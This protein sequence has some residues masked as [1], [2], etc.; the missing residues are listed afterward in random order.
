MK[1][2]LIAQ[3]LDSK[4]DNSRI[5]IKGW[6]RTKRD[7]KGFSFLEV[8]DGSC[9]KNIQII[10]DASNPAYEILGEVNTG[11]A[12]EVTG[13]L[14]PSPGKGQKWEVRANDIRVIGH[15]DAE[16]YPLQKKRHSDEF[17]RTIAHLR[18]RTNKYGALFRIRSESAFAVHQFFRNRG[19]YYLHTPIITGLDCE[20]AGELFRVTTLPPVSAEPE[21]ADHLFE[22]D[23]F[24]KEASL[25]VS[26]QLE[27]EMFACA[28]GNVYTFGPTFRAENSN[29]PRHS[30][31]F[32]MIEP[33]MAFA[34][35]KDN[36]DLSEELVKNLIAHVI[37][38]CGSDLELFSRFVDKNLVTQLEIIAKESYVR[39]PYGEAIE[40]LKAS[41]DIFE[42]PVDFGTDLQTE[43]ERFLCEKHFKKP[44]IVY[45]YPKQIK[46]FYMRLNDDNTTVA[47]MDLL[48]P[49]IGELIGGSQREER[50]AVLKQRI[51]ES[52]LNRD[53]YW[54]YLDIR[55]FGTAPHSGFGLGFE[56]F[57]MMV[58]GVT[59]IRDV[60]PFPRTPRHL[61]F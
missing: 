13:A 52:G 27:A 59:N 57:L 37:D 11:A 31:E 12:V 46:P 39:L 14:V 3:A 2:T 38:H 56:R 15:A 43:H 58:S 33:E 16:S 26:G 29:T 28:L 53:D 51:D 50:L 60:I 19:F 1:R 20:G 42:F 36:M 40:I 5:L 6:V 47:A 32:W 61:E 45:N 48:V 49:K 41:G 9:L 17:L 25:T 24:G 44:V 22:A 55:R 21:E 54:W 7:A 18:P 8:N 4:N 30:A 10:V 35:L 23:F 34:D